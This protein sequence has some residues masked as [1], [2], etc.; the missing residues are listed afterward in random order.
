MTTATKSTRREIGVADAAK[1]QAIWSEAAA[2]SRLAYIQN[3]DLDRTFPCGISWVSI[4]NR[5][6]FA[7][8]LLQ[9]DL[10]R[11][12]SYEGGLTIFAHA[13]NKDRKSVV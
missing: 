13:R 6:K 12:N 9:N 1:F 7:A 10:A 8:W 11:K 4:P 3:Q 5:G 2:A